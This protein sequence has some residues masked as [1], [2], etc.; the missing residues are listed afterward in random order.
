MTERWVEIAG[1]EGLYFV[2]D[3]GRIRSARR[4][5][6]SGRILKPSAAGDGY[7]KVTLCGGGARIAR[8]VHE[9]VLTHFV[10]PRPDGMEVAHNNGRR[11]DNRLANLRWDT[12]SG[13]HADKIIHGTACRGERH[14]RRKLSASDVV[15]IRHAKGSLREIGD[16][17]GVGPMQVHRILA[18]Q[19]WSS[20]K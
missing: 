13:N 7:R 4:Y 3:L 10:G 16:R 14:G 17:F 6:V 11:D 8:Y 18:G 20:L 1:F 19:N 5:R 15:A 2:S 12:R 9:L